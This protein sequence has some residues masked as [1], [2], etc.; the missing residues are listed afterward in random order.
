M[1]LVVGS[2]ARQV[3]HWRASLKWEGT[4][5]EG[6]ERRWQP[7]GDMGSEVFFPLFQ[8]RRVLNTLSCRWEG[9]RVME[10]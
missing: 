8:H 5:H 9:T 3:W 1:D 4:L 6:R 10:V 2:E 7:E